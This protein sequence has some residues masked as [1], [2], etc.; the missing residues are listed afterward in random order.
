MGRSTTISTLCHILF[1]P[2]WLCV[3]VISHG[4]YTI[5]RC[6]AWTWTGNVGRPKFFSTHL[7]LISLVPHDLKQSCLTKPFFE[8][9]VG[10]AY[11]KIF[12]GKYQSTLNTTLSRTDWL[13]LLVN[14][15]MRATMLGEGKVRCSVHSLW[16]FFKIVGLNLKKR[17][18]SFPGNWVNCEAMQ[19]C[20][21]FGKEMQASAVHETCCLQRIC[22]YNQC[23]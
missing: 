8:K 16:G 17:F 18:T 14:L 23:T 1:S 5:I 11:F 3:K 13:A 19:L 7:M 12:P 6:R 10:C 15:P 20:A 2:L 4:L 21:N 22:L 9:R